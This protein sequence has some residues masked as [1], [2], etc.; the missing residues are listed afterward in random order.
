MFITLAFQK[1]SDGDLWD[2]VRAWITK[3]WTKSKYFHVEMIIEDKWVHCCQDTGEIT[4]EDLGELDHE[5]FDYVVVE[6]EEKRKQFVWE[7]I[8]SKTPEMIDCLFKDN[9]R[10]RGSDLV[11]AALRRFGVMIPCSRKHSPQSVLEYLMES[12]VYDVD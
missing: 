11:V 4:V 7:L 1:K 6:V 12:E 9:H 8:T 2:R 3:T 5:K 10:W